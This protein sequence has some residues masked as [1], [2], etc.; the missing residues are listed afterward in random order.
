MPFFQTSLGAIGEELL[1]FERTFNNI[2]NE[3]TWADDDV[4]VDVAT[5]L[6]FGSGN[7]ED[8]SLGLCSSDY[9]G[10]GFKRK[11]DEASGSLTKGNEADVLKIAEVGNAV[12]F[13]FRRMT[14]S[15]SSRPSG[16]VSLISN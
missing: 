2:F 15:S 10:A 9:S 7:V 1:F 4:G 13:F 12:R 3:R 16:T 6:N 14:S 8:K 5:L 11:E